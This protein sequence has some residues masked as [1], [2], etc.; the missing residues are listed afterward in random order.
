MCGIITTSSSL[1][2]FS[3]VSLENSRL[4]SGTFARP[5]TPETA[6]DSFPCISPP[7]M[8]TSPSFTRRSWITRRW[9]I[10]GWLNPPT[11]M[12]SFTDETSSS[13][14]SDTSPELWMRGVMSAFTPTSAYW[15]CVLTRELTAV[16]ATPAE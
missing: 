9:P 16:V 14:W 12:V 2:L 11:L 4:S 5:G 13:T 8:L 1:A 7:R 6:F 15:N 3:T 10:T